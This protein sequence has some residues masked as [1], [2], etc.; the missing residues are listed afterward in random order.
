MA[1]TTLPVPASTATATATNNLVRYQRKARGALSP[2]TERALRNDTAV[3]TAWCAAHGLQGLP[4]LPE[5]V[6]RFIDAQAAV[7]APATVRRYVSS[8]ACLHRAAEQADPTKTKDA[9]LALKRMVRA[10]CAS[11]APLLWF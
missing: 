11:C 7:R 1:L 4:A 8:I 10:M 3:F 6:A 5:T 9:K 2:N